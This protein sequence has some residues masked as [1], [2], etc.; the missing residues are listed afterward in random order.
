MSRTRYR[1]EFRHALNDGQYNGLIN[2]QSI[3]SANGMKNWSVLNRL[4]DNSR[5]Y[6]REVLQK[7]RGNIA[8]SLD[9][10]LSLTATSLIRIAVRRNALLDVIQ[11]P[12]SARAPVGLRI[13][14]CDSLPGGQSLGLGL[15]R[16][17]SLALGL[18]NFN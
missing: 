14:R 4:H 8:S 6:R 10:G 15:L 5:D 7:I 13:L 17:F 16:F 12:L 3:T 11:E 18:V 9:S 2:R 1:N